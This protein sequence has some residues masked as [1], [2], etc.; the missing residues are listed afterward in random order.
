MTITITI[1]TGNAAFEEPNK[2]AEIERIIKAWL[3]DGIEKGSRRIYDYNG[4]AVG[5][6][7]VRGK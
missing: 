5:T 4:N 2:E 1:D 6:V 3:G 7:T